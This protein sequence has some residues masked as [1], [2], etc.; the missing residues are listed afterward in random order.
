MKILV[1]QNKNF[2]NQLPYY[3]NNYS[4]KINKPTLNNINNINIPQA[5]IMQGNYLYQV[6]INVV[7]ENICPNSNYNPQLMYTYSNNTHYE[8][9]LLPVN[10]NF[11]PINP[12]LNSNIT[13]NTL[14]NQNTSKNQNTNNVITNKIL[15]NK[16]NKKTQ[17]NSKNEMKKQKKKKII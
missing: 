10:K 8:N 2:S 1:T 9:K 12:V 7:N 17:K 13:Q 5:N 14:K 3:Q 11:I 4:M 16:K 6:P 15:I